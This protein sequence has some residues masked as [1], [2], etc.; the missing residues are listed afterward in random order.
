M[1]DEQTP[2][3]VDTSVLFSAL[4]R[5]RSKFAELLTRSEQSFYICEFVFVELFKHKDKL[6]RA[7]ELAEEDLLR[8]LYTILRRI[9]L[10]KENLIQYENRMQAFKLCQDIDENDTLHVALVLELNGLLWTGDKKLRTGLNAKGF[11]RFF[12][13]S[14]KG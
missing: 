3:I 9:N 4:V 13:P 6:I 8:Q 2:I 12:D 1:A 7:S 14:Q 5:E 10:F 11:D